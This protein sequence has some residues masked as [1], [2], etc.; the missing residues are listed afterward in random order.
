[1][2]TTIP[3]D[4]VRFHESVTELMEQADG[5][6]PVEEAMI[7]FPE[8]AKKVTAALGDI[9]K[10]NGDDPARAHDEYVKYFPVS[11]SKVARPF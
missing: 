2:S 11:P 8:T 9:I 10:R 5:Q 7:R 4:L 6:C 1:M 3:E